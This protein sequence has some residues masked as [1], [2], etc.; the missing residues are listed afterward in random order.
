MGCIYSETVLTDSFL[1]I[2]ND[3]KYFSSILQ[4]IVI[5]DKQ[6]LQ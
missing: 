5:E 4:D 3:A 6:L 2:S 1:E